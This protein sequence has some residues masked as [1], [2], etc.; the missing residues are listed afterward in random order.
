[1]L[2]RNVSFG[3]PFSMYEMTIGPTLERRVDGL[4]HVF[5]QLQLG[6]NRG[7]VLIDD[8]TMATQIL[9][10]GPLARFSRRPCDRRDSGGD[11][12]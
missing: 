2:P 12:R 1:V 3:A 8:S 9:A 6:Q 10:S 11:D 5:G 4:L 7:V